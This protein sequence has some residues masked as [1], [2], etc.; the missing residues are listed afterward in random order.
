MARRD[1]GAGKATRGVHAL[2]GRRR[3]ATR[4]EVFGDVTC[5]DGLRSSRRT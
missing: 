3:E 4:A 1:S 2:Q 5:G